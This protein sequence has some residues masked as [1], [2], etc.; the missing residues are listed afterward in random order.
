MHLMLFLALAVLGGCKRSLPAETLQTDPLNLTGE[1]GRNLSIKIEELRESKTKSGPHSVCAIGLA[2]NQSI[3]EKTAKEKLVCS[4]TNEFKNG[5]T[6]ELKN[7]PYPAYITLF[8]DQN[9]N[10]VLDFASLNL[11]VIRSSGPAE[12]IGGLDLGDKEIKFSRPIWVEVGD[13]KASAKIT[14]PDMPFWQVI[15]HESWSAFFDWYMRVADHV[16]NPNR[17]PPP[18]PVTTPE[19]TNPLEDLNQK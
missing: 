13:N 2:G 5:L 15:K 4:N 10:R 14:Y 17:E 19:G 1:T 6:I 11:L 16:N 3:S 9:N 8:H 18:F 12:G 7:L